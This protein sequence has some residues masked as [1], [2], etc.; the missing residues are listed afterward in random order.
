MQAAKGKVP[1]PADPVERK[2]LLDKLSEIRKS[3]EWLLT[4][5]AANV[6]GN[7][8][9]VT[10]TRPY[11]HRVTLVVVAA[12]MLLALLGASSWLAS[13]VDPADA[14]R[15]LRKTLVWRYTVR[16]VSLLLLVSAFVMLLLQIW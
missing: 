10:A 3:C 16:N 4:L 2:Y 15:R 6:F 11:L 8:L 7:L 9:K 13:D 12:E 14:E 1:T 5:G